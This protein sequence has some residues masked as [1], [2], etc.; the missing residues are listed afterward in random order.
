MKLN[1]STGAPNG[2]TLQPI[3]NESNYIPS[4]IILDIGDYT[5]TGVM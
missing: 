3:T 2:I 4:R 5:P 1:E